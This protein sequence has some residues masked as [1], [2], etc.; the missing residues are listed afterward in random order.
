[1]PIQ[2]SA[3]TNNANSKMLM[4]ERIVEDR[5]RSTPARM[6]E[7]A[8]LVDD[9]RRAVGPVH[10]PPA[11]RPDLVQLLREAEIMLGDARPPETIPRTWRRAVSSLRS[12][13]VATLEREMLR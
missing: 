1:M 5:S 9:F 4:I 6:N 3:V 2:P 10:A 13:I 12:R 11:P 7:I 8:A